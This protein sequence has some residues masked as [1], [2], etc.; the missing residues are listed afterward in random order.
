MRIWDAGIRGRCNKCRVLDF[1]PPGI[2]C[3]YL[4]LRNFEFPWKEFLNWNNSPQDQCLID[5]YLAI[6]TKVHLPG[7]G[8]TVS[9]ELNLF[10]LPIL[11]HP[12]LLCFERLYSPFLLN[13]STT[14]YW[15]GP[16]FYFYGIFYIFMTVERILI[17]GSHGEGKSL[18]KKSFFIFAWSGVR[19]KIWWC[20][21]NKANFFI[22]AE[23]KSFFKFGGR[24]WII[25]GRWGSKLLASEGR[26]FSKAEG[27]GPGSFG[28]ISIIVWFFTLIFFGFFESWSLGEGVEVF[29]LGGVEW[30][31]EFLIVGCLHHLNKF[32]NNKML[33]Y[34]VKVLFFYQ[35]NDE[36]K[37]TSTDEFLPILVLLSSGF[38][39]RSRT[40]PSGLHLS[41][42]WIGRSG[43]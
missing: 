38:N 36:P 25:L 11:P 43:R 34:R 5:L 31:F 19:R 23:G 2:I 13:G 4:E 28:R 18:F 37:H 24:I 41:L 32:M 16:N 8:G 26:S 12:E 21:V 33:N 42:Q 17:F 15:P 35:I 14:L 22:I 10:S 1:L 27:G 6:R 7:P 29:G 30:P 20:L 39:R 3:L 9:S 40:S